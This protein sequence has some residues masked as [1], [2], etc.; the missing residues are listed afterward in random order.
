MAGGKEGLGDRGRDPRFESCQ[1]IEE[2]HKESRF[3]STIYIAESNPG[4]NL[5][6]GANRMD[7]IFR[8]I[9]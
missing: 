6:R 2:Q 4:L 8:E 9:D 7:T 5:V 1:S 3:K